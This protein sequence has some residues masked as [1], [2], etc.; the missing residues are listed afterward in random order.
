MNTRKVLVA[1]AASVVIVVGAVVAVVVS[2]NA[3]A[4]EPDN[5]FGQQAPSW[6]ASGDSGAL[7]A[8]PPW[9]RVG[10]GANPSATLHVVGDSVTSS[11][12][13]G[14]LA[15]GEQGGLHMRVDRNDLL[16][17]GGTKGTYG[18]LYLQ[19]YGG[20]I[21]VH[22]GRPLKD[23]LYITVEGDIGV[24]TADPAKF[25]DDRK[26]GHWPDGAGL[27]NGVVA[28]DGKVVAMGLSAKKASIKET[29]YVGRPVLYDHWAA[30][31]DTLH[32]DAVVQVAGKLTAQAIVVH[33]DH[34]A[35]DVFDADYELPP[36]SDVERYI[37]SEGHLP[38]VP[39]EAEVA[40]GLDLGDVT[41]ALL[42]Q[43][44]ELTLH[45][46]AQQK[47]LEELGRKVATCGR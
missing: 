26:L 45:T 32:G 19:R 9:V 12:G 43:V 16:V 22:G 46:I 38:G 13:T 15:V 44:E 42:R 40:T 20:P 8:A 21:V 18:A 3:A 28:V 33:Q 30:G 27:P 39:V 7:L 41:A 36:L 5:G 1:S 10:I 29:L 23:R 47:Q 4:Q 2:R 35:D 11:P 25:A 17:S 31:A 14:T 34:W 37:R 6:I 24:G